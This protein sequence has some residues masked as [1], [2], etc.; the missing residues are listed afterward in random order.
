MASAQRVEQPGAG[1]IVGE[2]T[3]QPTV[4]PEQRGAGVARAVPALMAIGIGE[5]ADA[6]ALFQSV[7]QQP[8]EGGSI[9]MH[10][11]RAL[12]PRIV[13]HLDVGIAS[14]DVREHDAILVFQRIE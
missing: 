12:D 5:D 13:R 9:G 11:D 7:V 10:L 14:A 1:Q 8:L 6:V 2:K 3:G 4:G